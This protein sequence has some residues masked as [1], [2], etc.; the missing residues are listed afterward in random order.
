VTQLPNPALASSSKAAD[1]EIDLRQL[2]AVLQRHWRLIAK[3]AG[4]A[5]LLSTVYA[6]VTPR[7][8]Q[9]EFQI[10]LAS[11]DTGG[12][13]LASLLAANPMLANLAGP[14][15]SKDS[16]ETEVKVLESPSVLKP[17]FDYVRTSKQRAGHNVD[18]LRFSDWVDTVKVE[19]EKGTSGDQ[20]DFERISRL[21]RPRPPPR[22]RQRRGLPQ[23]EH[24]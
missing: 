24:R 5:L 13:R 14:G 10:V 6:L 20:P 7:V 18:G 21:F 22:H 23:A 19:L 12:G 15:G 11:S 4:S 2:A 3:V 16:L 9:G 8:W 17:V 1:D